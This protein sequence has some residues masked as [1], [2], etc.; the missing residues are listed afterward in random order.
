[1][2]PGSFL[3]LS[4]RE[5]QILDVVYALG[6]ASAAE[7]VARMPEE[8]GDASVRKLVR[9]L[10]EKGFLAHARR[11]REHLYRPTIPHGRASRSALR[12]VVEVFFGGSAAKA[13]AALLDPKQRRLSA[14]E[15]RTLEQLIDKASEEGR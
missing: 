14:A 5:R 7:I 3:Y 10:E 8:A 4:K 15:R 12:H 13:A 1:M 11:G 2:A 9:I 6:E